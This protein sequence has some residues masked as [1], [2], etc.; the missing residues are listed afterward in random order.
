MISYPCK[1]QLSR[2]ETFTIVSALAFYLP[3][4]LFLIFV[5]KNGCIKDKIMSPKECEKLQGFFRVSGIQVFV[6]AFLYNVFSRANSKISS[7]NIIIGTVISRTLFAISVLYL[8]YIRKFVSLVTVR[9]SLG[10][11]I[12][13]SMTTVALWAFLPSNRQSKGFFQ[14]VWHLLRP[15]TAFFH[16]SS[17]VVHVLG[18]VQTILGFISLVFTK[19]VLHLLK[20]SPK[21]LDNLAI[22]NMCLGFLL[23]T[24]IG[25]IHVLAGGADSRSFNIASVFYR[26]FITIPS[27]LFIG[28]RK[29]EFPKELAKCYIIIDGIF[30]VIVLIT[31]L[32]ESKKVKQS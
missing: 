23:F 10:L 30:A 12:T 31:L 26:V 14:S 13:L 1:K 22:G 16:V 2:L 29:A 4:S 5:P 19:E 28:F 32:V 21:L 27:M 7:H 8:L 6:I 24:K 17:F 20:I 25:F 11:D 18:Y 15:S 3:M 9:K